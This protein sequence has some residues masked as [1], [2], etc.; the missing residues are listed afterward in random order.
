MKIVLYGY[1]KTVRRIKACLEFSGAEI[2]MVYGDPE[3]LLA[4]RDG[5]GISMAILDVTAV[6]SKKVYEHIKKFW[7]IPV[8]LLL[9]EEE[10]DW[11]SMQELDA[12]GYLHRNV[13]ETEIIARIEAINRRVKK[14]VG[15]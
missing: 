13:G 3:K 1:D 15:R 6:D 14:S 8:I 11:S 12:D 7:D 4:M 2:P 9:S 10:N 5:D